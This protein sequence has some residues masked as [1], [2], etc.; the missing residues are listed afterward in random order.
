M[1]W[2]TFK[3]FRS[4]QLQP[5]DAG[6]LTQG[7][8]NKH[9]SAQGVTVSVL[10]CWSTLYGMIQPQDEEQWQVPWQGMLMEHGLSSPHPKDGQQWSWVVVRK[11]SPS[12]SLPPWIKS[13]ERRE[14]SSSI[15]KEI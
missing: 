15:R 14:L 9:P 10:M 12:L 5:V 7:S 2:E 8:K 6:I 1:G 13:P 11:P 4:L 3:P